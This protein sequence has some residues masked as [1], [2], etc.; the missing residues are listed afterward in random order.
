LKREIKDPERFL[1]RPETWQ[2]L[3]SAQLGKQCKMVGI[4]CGGSKD[5]RCQ[6]LVRWRKD[7]AKF[8]RAEAAKK[9]KKKAKP[10]VSKGK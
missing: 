1:L 6:R 10:A 5:D 4:P 9:K 2:L 7:P 8:E 3:D